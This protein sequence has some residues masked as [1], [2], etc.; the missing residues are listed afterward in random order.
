MGGGWRW[1]CLKHYHQ[2][3]LYESKPWS[4]LIG[5]WVRRKI[6]PSTHRRRRRKKKK[7]VLTV[8]SGITYRKVEHTRWINILGK[9]MAGYTTYIPNNTSVPKIHPTFKDLKNLP[10]FPWNKVKSFPKSLTPH[11]CHHNHL[12]TISIIVF[13]DISIV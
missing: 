4:W 6:E 13:K 8:L 11:R 7:G 2:F 9:L 1:R 10:I 12:G 5:F 3:V